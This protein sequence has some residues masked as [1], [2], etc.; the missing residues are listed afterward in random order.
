M[1]TNLFLGLC[2][3]FVCASLL[4]ISVQATAQEF[5]GSIS[6]QVT[7]RTGVGISGAQVTAINTATNV[8][9]KAATDSTGSYTVLYLTP[10][11][12]TI[13]VEAPGFKKLERK[14]IEVRVR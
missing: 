13:A 7:D 10:G 3:V 5:R 12:Y 14:G 1:K 6:G 9:T 2:S 11:Q 8:G 4:L